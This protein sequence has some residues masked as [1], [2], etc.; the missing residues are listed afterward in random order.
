MRF[1]GRRR[2]SPW[3]NVLF[4][5]QR[6]PH[7]PDRGDRITTHHVLRFLRE[8]GHTVR[9]GCLAEDDRDLQAVAELGT[10]GHEVCAPR[11]DR[12]ARRLLALRGL[13]TGEALTLPFFRVGALQ[14]QVAAWLRASPPD[15]V[16]VYSSGMAQYVLGWRGGRK[17]MQFAELDSDKWRQYA[18]LRSGLAG[19]IYR[20]E[21]AR[22]LAFEDR[23]AHDFDVSFV[24][25]EVEQELFV[26]SIPGVVPV[27]LRNG[28]DV[29]FFASRGDAGR[30]PHA[31]IFTGVMDYEPN[32]AGVTWFV[33][34]CWPA[35]RARVPDA[36]FY[37]VGSRPTAAITALDGHDGITVTGRVE[38]TPPWFDRCAL[39]IAPLHLARGVQ[40]KV[41]E[42]MS[43]GLPVVSTTVAA[44]GLGALDPGTLCVA[45]TAPAFAQE[46]L[47]LLADPARR[48]AIGA[49][50]RAC[51]C[52]RFR[53]ETQFE[54][55][56]QVLAGL[57]AKRQPE[58]R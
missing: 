32:V 14:R 16:Y 44:Q 3:L 33:R 29:E 53:W 5:A 55:L 38:Q 52:A 48:R 41:L 58:S 54:V 8:A 2:R 6:V 56:R 17:L 35:V 1:R 15:L 10:L 9:I 13:L 46:V 31:V 23:V 50:A 45:D 28:V 4:L 49:R 37:V 40:N 21:A 34:E 43:M 7:P 24:V 27:V 26:R 22:L 20:R 30:E 18:A 36:R 19:W 39:A 25:S 51:V 12:R 57:D 47:A 42:A 11:I